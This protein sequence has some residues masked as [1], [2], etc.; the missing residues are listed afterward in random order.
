MSEDMTGAFKATYA[1]LYDRHLVPML[2]AP[3]AL[4]V[5]AEKPLA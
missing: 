1:E 4:I 3:Y 5:A 2:F